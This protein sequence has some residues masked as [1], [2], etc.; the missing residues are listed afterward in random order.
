MWKW[1]TFIPQNTIITVLSSWFFRTCCF[2]A[3]RNTNSFATP[4]RKKQICPLAGFEPVSSLCS[5]YRRMQYIA[6]KEFNVEVFVS[7]NMYSNLPIKLPFCLSCFSRAK[8]SKYSFFKV[9]CL[10]HSGRFS[11]SKTYLGLTANLLMGLKLFRIAYKAF[12]T[13]FIIH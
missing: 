7:L 6:T 1:V 12:T 4:L 10:C 8:F 5:L 13:C 9:I 11:Q 2:V 3:F